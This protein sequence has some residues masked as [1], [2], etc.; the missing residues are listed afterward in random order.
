MEDRKIFIDKMSAKLKEWDAEIRK[1]EAKADTVKADAKAG[2]L[3]QIDELRGRKEEARQKLE[4]IREA[5][6]EAWEDLKEG[7]EQSW[8]ILGDSVRNAFEKFKG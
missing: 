8:K 3:R 2:Y 7:A 6:E 4:E 1:L 5:G